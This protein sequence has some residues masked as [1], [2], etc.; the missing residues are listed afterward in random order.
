MEIRETLTRKSLELGGTPLTS[1]GQTLL[2]DAGRT[3]VLKHGTVLGQIIASGKWKPFNPVATD[4]AA[5]NVGIYYGEDLPVAKIT[6]GDVTNLPIIV[7]GELLILNESSITVENSATLDTAIG[8]GVTITSLR[9]VL[10][11][12]GIFPATVQNVYEGAY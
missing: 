9:N 8:T 2:I 6:A 10:Y 5:T 12:K 7:G 4:G 11:S 3:T 1:D